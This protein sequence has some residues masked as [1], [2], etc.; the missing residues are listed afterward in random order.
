[1]NHASDSCRISREFISDTGTTTLIFERFRPDEQVD[2][3][4]AGPAFHTS[5]SG[6]FAQGLVSF[7]PDGSRPAARQIMIG[8]SEPD[9]TVLILFG[10]WDLLNRSAQPFG[11]FSVPAPSPAQEK[12]ISAVTLV[13]GDEA[14]T[15]QIDTLGAPMAAM[16]ECTD[17][18]VRDWGLDPRQQAALLHKVEPLGSPGT[19]ATDFDMP[20]AMR[21]QRMNVQARFRLMIDVKGKPT[22]CYIQRPLSVAG[23]GALTCRLLLERARFKPAQ[24][25]TGRPVP[26]YYVNAINWFSGP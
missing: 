15:F 14:R 22:A 25:A 24:D 17:A 10:K 16:R 7:S 26:S 18:L 19:W 21:R 11:K 9:G 6:V 23:L 12:V 2:V 4:L 3:L 20:P 1:M 8:T 13:V 5:S